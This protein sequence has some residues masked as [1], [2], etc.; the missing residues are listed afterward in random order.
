M[1]SG[2][3]IRD[4]FGVS[5]TLVALCPATLAV[6]LKLRMRLM[7]FGARTTDHGALV[8]FQRIQSTV[9]DQ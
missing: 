4:P 6:A 2:S 1:E 3:G 5:R 7:L 8:V 9:G